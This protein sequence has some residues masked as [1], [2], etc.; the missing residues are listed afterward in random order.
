MY[1]SKKFLLILSVVLLAVACGNKEGEVTTMADE[2]G[3]VEVTSEGTP[4]KIT[5]TFRGSGSV[6]VYLQYLS[7]QQ[8]VEV[9]TVNTYAEGNFSFEMS[10]DVAGFYRIALDQNNFCVLVVY[11]GESISVDADGS[12][13]Y[14][15]YSVTGSEESSRLQ[16][17]NKLLAPRDSINMAFQNAQMTRDQQKFQEVV[18]VYDGIMA[19]VMDQVKAFIDE[20]PA[21]LT[22]LAAAQNLNID[23]DFPYYLKVIDALQGKADGNDFYEAVSTQVNAQ[24]KLAIGSPAPEIALNQPNGEELKLSDLRGQY[25]LIDFWASWCG[26]CR[27]ENPN[28][29]RVYNKYHDKGFEILGVSL[30]KNQNAWL[31]AIDQ[32]GLTWR[33]VSDLKFWNSAVVPEYQVKGIP[34]TYLVDSEGNIVGKNLRG[35]S[36]ENKLAEIFGE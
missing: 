24:R 19:D 21:T 15:T 7:A 17:L 4:T 9:D 1:I 27:K 8:L 36:L 6:P 12:S 13:I 2:S 16:D 22:A 18:A 33:H 10:I 26:P 3:Q 25:V 29:V 28:V 30:D 20:D 23:E 14:A 11:P 32:D 5:G 31:N 35:R 34:L